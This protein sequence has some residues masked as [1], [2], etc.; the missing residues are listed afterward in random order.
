MLIFIHLHSPLGR[1][2]GRDF[3]TQILEC[4]SATFPSGESRGI[5]GEE[6]QSAGNRRN[7]LLGPTSIAT[8]FTDQR[9][10]FWSCLHPLLYFHSSSALARRHP[11]FPR[12]PRRFAIWRRIS[13]HLTSIWPGPH[14]Y[15]D[16]IS[17]LLLI[18]IL[19]SIDSTHSLTWHLW[20]F[21]KSHEK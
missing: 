1:S 6:E 21:R 14:P 5:D 13:S 7:W 16:K 9:H 11:S 19:K 15:Y 17:L 2:Q 18:F 8:P 10:P 3:L 20:V 12:F 4:N